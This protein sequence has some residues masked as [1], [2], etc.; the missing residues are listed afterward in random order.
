MAST[1]T[2]VTRTAGTRALLYA[3]LSLVTTVGLWV[4]VRVLAEITGWAWGAM[5]VALAAVSVP[6]ALVV[7]LIRRLTSDRLETI[8]LQRV[9]L[10]AVGAPVALSVAWG[11][12]DAV[13]R[14]VW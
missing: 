6:V 8:R 1:E 5:G 4:V 12:L 10:V 11:L 14:S 13:L 9:A 7:A 2:V 3:A